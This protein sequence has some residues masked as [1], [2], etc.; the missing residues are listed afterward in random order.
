MKIILI[1]GKAQHG[2][3]FYGKLIHDQL[4]RRNKKVLIMHFADL[5]KYTCSQYLNWNGQ[6]DIAGRTLLQTVGTDWRMNFD[7]A[8]WAE[9]T[10]RLAKFLG[11]QYDYI[12][13]PDWRFVIEYHTMAKQ[14]GFT[15]IYTIKVKRY[16]DSTCTVQYDNGLTLQ[17][18]THPSE[19][20]LDKFCTQYLIDNYQ[21][22]QYNNIVTEIMNDLM[23]E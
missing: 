20:Q 17:Q 21:N 8:I 18:K 10:A 5:V 13:I 22:V 7:E 15:N 23:G 16:T 11:W 9:M 6:K 3:D 1:N 14:F 12:L 4:V 19:I 2:K